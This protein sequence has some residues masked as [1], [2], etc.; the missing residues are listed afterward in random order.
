MRRIHPFLLALVASALLGAG[1]MTGAR[2]QPL[3]WDVVSL[4]DDDWHGSPRQAPL[5]EGEDVVLR[6]QDI[7]TQ[8]S[9]SAPVTVEF[10]AMLESR[11]ADD[12]ALTCEFVPSTQAVDRE[13]ERHV[14]VLL[15]YDQHGEA[16]SVQE[17]FQRWP[18]QKYK[19]W[20][21][22]PLSIK[23][24]SWHHM[25]YEVMKGGLNITVDGQAYG[26][27]GA[28]V[29]HK[30]FYVYLLSWQPTSRWH[31]RNFWIH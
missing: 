21:R 16:V 1:C 26:S 5:I 4:K 31:V 25:K 23:P 7:R 12:G 11:V 29:P 27:G 19:T 10:D 22:A 9:Y 20:S 6:G 8:H 24:G 30:A 28:V 14:Q 13:P 2:P 3:A 17:R 18:T 15:Q